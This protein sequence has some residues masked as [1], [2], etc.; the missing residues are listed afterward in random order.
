MTAEHSETSVQ[1][2]PRTAEEW[3][4]LITQSMQQ[5]KEQRC[6]DSLSPDAIGALDG[7]GRLIFQRQ[8][9]VEGVCRLMRER[10]RAD[11]TAAVYLIV[12]TGRC[13]R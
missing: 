11:C 4:A 1:A 9:V 13:W 7:A 5:L 8:V 2:E 12:V 10:P 3:I 6:R